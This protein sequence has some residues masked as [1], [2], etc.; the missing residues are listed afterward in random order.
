MKEIESIK[1]HNPGEF[2]RQLRKLGKTKGRKTV[3]DTAIDE[4]GVE[5]AGEKSNLFGKQ[6]TRI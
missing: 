6:L 1:T 2:W 4:E 5:V 3:W